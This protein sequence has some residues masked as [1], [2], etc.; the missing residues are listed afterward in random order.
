MAAGDSRGIRDTGVGASP[1]SEDLI[2]A[3]CLH[4]CPS[5]VPR[6]ARAGGR[7]GKSPRMYY[8]EHAIMGRG[9]A[10][11][12]LAPALLASAKRKSK[13]CSSSIRSCSGLGLR[14]VEAKRWDGQGGLSEAL[15]LSPAAMKLASR[16]TA[17][18]VSDR[19][20]LPP[21]LLADGE[22]MACS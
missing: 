4:V 5:G 8:V 13:T 2:P 19:R 15:T 20:G 6:P 3:R 12:S 7:R 14:L 9:D 21:K 11:G 17:R 16:R 1:P 18:H 10:H 22:A